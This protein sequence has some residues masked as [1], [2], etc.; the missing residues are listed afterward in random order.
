MSGEPD[1]DGM[2]R[3]NILRWAGHILRKHV[4]RIP[5]KCYES[6]IN[7]LKLYNR[8]NETHMKTKSKVDR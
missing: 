1:I 4:K 2:I 8:W 6:H 7:L 3:G 5:K